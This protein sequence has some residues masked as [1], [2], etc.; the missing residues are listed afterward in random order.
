[1][2]ARFE[3]LA[4]GAKCTALVRE[5]AHRSAVLH[6]QWPETRTAEQIAAARIDRMLFMAE[7]VSA[8]CL[9]N[10]NHEGKGRSSEF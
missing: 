6:L 3:H 7:M 4:H 1:M 9:G 5:S 8:A 2:A 10:F